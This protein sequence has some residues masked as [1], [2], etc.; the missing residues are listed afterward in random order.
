MDSS[1]VQG[2]L[3]GMFLISK[4]IISLSEGEDW[5]YTSSVRKEF[6]FILLSASQIRVIKLST[7]DCLK[8]EIVRGNWLS[9]DTIC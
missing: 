6:N 3:G 8:C 4:L 5:T 1:V 9:Q 7:Q 2:S